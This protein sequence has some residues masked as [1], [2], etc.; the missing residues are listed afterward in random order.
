MEEWMEEKAE[1]MSETAQRVEK[2]KSEIAE[3]EKT[4]SELQV[5][6]SFFPHLTNSTS[7]RMKS[8]T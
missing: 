1:I 3:K 5:S 7:F 8:P 6:F 4:I 2:L